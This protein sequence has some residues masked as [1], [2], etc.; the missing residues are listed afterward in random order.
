MHFVMCDLSSSL[1]PFRLDCSHE[2]PTGLGQRSGAGGLS[3]LAPP[4]EGGAQ[5][6][7]KQMEEILVCPEEEFSVLVHRQDGESQLQPHT[8]EVVMEKDY[9]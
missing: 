1:A 7:G 9:Y 6:P 3:G 2:S 4:Q 8:L 5:L